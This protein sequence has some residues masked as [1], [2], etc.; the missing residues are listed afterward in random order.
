MN[1]SPPRV[2]DDINLTLTPKVKTGFEVPNGKF[3]PVHTSSFAPPESATAL[4]ETQVIPYDSA[5]VIDQI[6]K[7]IDAVTQRPTQLQPRAA[8]E[9]YGLDPGADVAFYKK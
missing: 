7:A 1:S 5:Q 9:V 2:N 4:A 6:K 3:R 8:G